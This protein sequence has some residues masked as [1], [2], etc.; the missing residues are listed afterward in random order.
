MPSFFLNNNNNNKQLFLWES[1]FQFTCHVDTSSPSSCPAPVPLS[2][3]TV[4]GTEMEG[5]AA[6]NVKKC[7]LK[8]FVS[9]NQPI[10]FEKKNQ[11]CHDGD[12]RSSRCRRGTAAR[13]H[14]PQ[15]GW[16]LPPLVP[17]ASV[18]RPLLPDGLP[19]RGRLPQAAHS[20]EGAAVGKTFYLICGKLG[21]SKQNTFKFQVAMASVHVLLIELSHKQVFSC[22]DAAFQ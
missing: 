9:Q 4:V 13:P 3:G 21:G 8:H 19:L 11:G 2:N 18:R 16:L 5:D 12:G 6:E 10:S 15:H 14:L 7:F 22:F 1:L 20:A 17:R